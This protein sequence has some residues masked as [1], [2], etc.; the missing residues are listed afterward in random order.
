MK[1][2][3]QEN[4]GK[5]LNMIFKTLPLTPEFTSQQKFLQKLEKLL[6]EYINKGEDFIDN[7]EVDT[8]LVSIQN[9][10]RD[11]LTHNLEGKLH[12]VE[13]EH[14][15]KLAWDA[16]NYTHITRNTHEFQNEQQ[17]AIEK[18]IAK[19]PNFL[20]KPKQNYGY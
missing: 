3:T 16:N 12:S 9:N 2:I 7:S 18:L 5:L 4:Y 1:T 13:K 14:Y 6:L 10:M 19:G 20:N 17:T 8:F 15:S 11:Y